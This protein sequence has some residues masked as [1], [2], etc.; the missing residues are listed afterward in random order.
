MFKNDNSGF[1]LFQEPVQCS[2]DFF[3]NFRHLTWIPG[4]NQDSNGRLTPLP[5]ASFKVATEVQDVLALREKQ[6]QKGHPNFQGS[7]GG[8]YRAWHSF[9]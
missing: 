5:L 4:R 2:L 8:D 3:G 9:R 1:Q 6:S 7:I